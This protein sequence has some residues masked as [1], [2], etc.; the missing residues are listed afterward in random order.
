MKDKASQLPPYTR[1]ACLK[2]WQSLIHANYA[3]GY[4]QIPRP[5]A[6]EAAGVL[7]P[8]SQGAMTMATCEEASAP[9]DPI[10]L[11]HKSVSRPEYRQEILTLLAAPSG[12]ELTASY[13]VK[14]IEKTLLLRL[15]ADAGAFRKA[16]GSCI[17]SYAYRE[18]T[19]G[20]LG[21]L[22]LRECEIRGI[23]VTESAVHFRVRARGYWVSAE[24]GEAGCHS[25]FK[26]FSTRIR[27][28]F[29]QKLVTG[30]TA[31]WVMMGE[32]SLLTGWSQGEHSL[33][34]GSNI[35]DKSRGWQ[36]L[37][38]IIGNDD[39]LCELRNRAVILRVTV[40]DS[41][42]R[43]DYS[44]GG[45]LHLEEGDRVR[46]RVQY[47]IADFEHYEGRGAGSQERADRIPSRTITIRPTCSTLT[48][49]GY[50]EKPLAKYGDFTFEIHCDHFENSSPAQIIVQAQDGSCDAPRIVLECD[51]KK[52][53]ASDG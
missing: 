45:V 18:N 33:M 21:Y 35:A 27:D 19:L 37:L 23:S 14:H 5:L 8:R 2:R 16:C 46:F 26:E 17:V 10:L 38:D 29:G 52:A 53:Y 25:G 40:D 39:Q 32:R 24:S 12:T 28:Y 22:P 1:Q 44:E 7:R 15:K 20:G 47:Q 31:K 11:L 6:F 42:R 48:V 51:L 49:N 13:D 30:P 34:C 3:I 50:A 9:F 36:H 41:D 4:G 43:K